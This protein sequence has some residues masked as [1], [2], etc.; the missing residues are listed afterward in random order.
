MDGYIGEIRM[1]PYSFSPVP[2]LVCAGQLLYITQ[3]PALYSIIGITYGGNGKTNFNLPNFSGYGMSDGI[4]F[5]PVGV[6]I[7]GPGGHKWQL[8]ISDGEDTALCQGQTPTHNHSLMAADVALAAYGSNMTATPNNNTYL[9]RA[10]KAEPNKPAGNWETIPMY[11][12][13]QATAG[14]LPP[15]TIGSA[16]G[17]PLPKVHENRQPFTGMQFCICYD[18]LYPV[19]NN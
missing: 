9:S 13:T 8:G 19:P 1:F 15:Q 11:N 6:G 14:T 7:S 3:Y 2:W 4:G 18:G 12:T 17:T 16:F 5:T 10:I